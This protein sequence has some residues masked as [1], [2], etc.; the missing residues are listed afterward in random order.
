MRWSEKKWAVFE[1]LERKP[2]PISLKELLRSLG[3]LHKERS[4]RRY[5]VE[6][7]NEGLINRI[8]NRRATL[9]EVPK[10]SYS[11]VLREIDSCFSEKSLHTIHLIRKPLFLRPPVTYVAEWLAAYVPNYTYYVPKHVRMELENQGKRS[12]N[13]ASAGTYAYKIFRRLL[14]D[15]SYNSSRLEGNT[16]TLLDTARLLFEGKGIEGKPD[17]EKLMILNHKEAI[18]Y[19]VDH[20]GRIKISIDTLCTFHY[21]LA[22]G[23]IDPQ[24]VGKIRSHGVR[25]CG[26]TYIPYENPRRLSAL[27][28]EIAFKAS[29]IHDPHE[30]SF[31]LLVHL[32]YLQPFI[33]VNK[34]TARL[35]ANI[36]LV[37]RNLVP[38]S[39]NDIEREDYISAIIAI[40]ELQDIQPLLD[41]YV[42]SYLRTCAQY[43]STV[44]GL[45]IDAIRVQY[46][47][48]RRAILH[49]I[50][51]CKLHDIALKEHILSTTK[52]Q[53][54]LEDQED[55][56]EDIYQDLEQMDVSRLAGLGITADQL[57]S[58]QADL[59][60]M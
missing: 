58:W 4:I 8:G 31:F 32:S 47:S 11:E 44:E 21:L 1:E 2:H 52:Q 19:L 38:L 28:H 33:D 24:Y 22:D 26:S 36:P 43:D 50:I 7:L 25:I 10:K 56:I 45:G 34:R 60:R 17:E 49:D 37:Q 59:Q 15:L 12:K 41:L 9:Y 51:A 6:M 46:R 42:Y 40:Y 30:Q 54:P 53:I 14:I 18:R 27:F 20:A 35:G 57:K 48:Q 5:L 23:L 16:Y 13:T 55:F 3:P 39:F 29:Q